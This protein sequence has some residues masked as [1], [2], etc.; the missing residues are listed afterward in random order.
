M[1][2]GFHLKTIVGVLLSLCNDPHP[3]VHFWALEGLTR[4]AESAGLTFSGYVSSTLGML[5][6]LYA[7]DTHNEEAASFVTSNIEAEHPTP[8]VISR[9]VDSLINVLGP[10]LQDMTKARGL[11]FTLVGNFQLE[12]SPS[13]LIESSKCLEHLS[14]Y[15]PAYV[16]FAKYVRGLQA[17]L[18]S[19]N[20]N[21]RETSING[22]NNLMKRNAEEVVRT[23]A[24]GLEDALWLALDQTPYHEGL[25]NMIRNWLQQTG[26]SDTAV[27]IQRCQNVLSKLRV[28]AEEPVP[29]TAA[30]TATA[31]PT[32]VDEEVAG[33]AS[34][35]A[36]MQSESTE[37]PTTGQEYLKW[38]TRSFA[39][40]CL[41]ELMIMVSNEL[42]PD[43]TIPAESEL[44]HGIADIVRMAFSASTAN[45]IELRIWGLRIIDQVLKVQHLLFQLVQCGSNYKTDVR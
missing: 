43:Q 44:Q 4:V 34:A 41:S 28:K 26:L 36:G 13:I 33:F 31:A 10:D 20:H 6:Q 17:D 1:A 42:L 32:L 22:L 12:D 38:Q 21:V 2:A 11:I 3:T 39:M 8:L 15:A 19:S 45:V 5:A 14:L 35:A 37:A 24:P 27:W 9:C 18:D 25:Q 16:E 7:T 30:K 40:S 23:A 29:T